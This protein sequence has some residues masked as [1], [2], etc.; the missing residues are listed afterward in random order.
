M[1]MAAF[2]DV[3]ENKTVVVVSRQQSR[4]ESELEQRLHQFDFVQVEPR[5][6]KP[7]LV[8]LTSAGL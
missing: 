6:C 3:Q 4:H 8:A 7:F 2:S 1:T 5:E